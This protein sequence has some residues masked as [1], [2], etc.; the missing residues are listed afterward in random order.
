[1][2]GNPFDKVNRAITNA[3]AA[4]TDAA[5]AI[6]GIGAVVSGVSVLD[7]ITKNADLKIHKMQNLVTENPKKISD[8][9]ILG[10]REGVQHDTKMSLFFMS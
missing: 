6:P 9:H 4:A 2:H 3:I 10:R 7:K 5:K 1:M 8:V